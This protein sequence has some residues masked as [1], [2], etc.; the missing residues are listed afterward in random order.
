MLPIIHWH[1]QTKY[2]KRKETLSSG[3]GEVKEGASK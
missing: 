1:M 2:L 3:R